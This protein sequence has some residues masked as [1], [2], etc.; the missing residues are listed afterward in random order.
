M[1]KIINFRQIGG[2]GIT[3]EDGRKV[4][5]GLL[6]R[7]ART[8]SA[9][10]SDKEYL[11]NQVGLKSII[12]MRGLSEYSKRAKKP[13]KDSFTT[14]FMKSGL[15]KEQSRPTSTH[16]GYMYVIDIIG[17][18]YAWHIMNKVNVFLWS[19]SL[20]LIAIDA[21]FGTKL[22]IH[23]FAK[24]VVNKMAVWEHYMDILEVAKPEIAVILRLV[25][26]PLNL[27]C[28]VHCELGKDRTGYI[29]ALI[30]ACIGIEDD[31][32]IKDY[33]LTEVN[34]DDT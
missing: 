2:K 12:D 8:D 24:H 31:V 10:D 5:D 22:T 20:V 6:F 13:F 29:S 21:V 4:K 11:K 30:L 18:K 34:Y 23:F 28:L 33:A 26:D 19:W 9:T 15:A 14:I 27:P 32:I 1:E 16:Q 7:S 25:S 17:R 3:T